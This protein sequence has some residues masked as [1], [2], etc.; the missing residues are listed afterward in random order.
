MISDNPRESES[1]MNSSSF[2]D[3]ELQQLKQ[4]IQEMGQTISYLQKRV[5]NVQEQVDNVQAEVNLKVDSA[6]EREMEAY[7]QL[8]YEKGFSED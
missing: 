7:W 3:S 6:R 1:E 5:D 2:S 8:R 4:I